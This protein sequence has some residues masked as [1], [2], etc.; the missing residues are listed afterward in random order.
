MC[1]IGEVG[2]AWFEVGFGQGQS[3]AML[4]VVVVVV[5]AV[6]LFE[7]SFVSGVMSGVILAA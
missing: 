2:A 7:L 1:D 5:V 3:C 4:L 6:V